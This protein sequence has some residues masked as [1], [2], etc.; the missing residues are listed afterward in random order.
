MP[1][2][3]NFV[4]CDIMDLRVGRQSAGAEQ[5]PAFIPKKRTHAA[6]I[7]ACQH[8]AMAVSAGQAAKSLI[9]VSGAQT[10]VREAKS[11][12]K[13]LLRLLKTTPAGYSDRLLGAGAT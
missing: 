3:L 11:S 4:R 10:P 12:L 6:R 13:T 9:R 8:P 7:Q 2:P 1:A 5:S